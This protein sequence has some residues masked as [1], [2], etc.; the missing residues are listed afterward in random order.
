MFS[1]VTKSKTKLWSWWCVHSDLNYYA[2]LATQFEVFTDILAFYE[3]QSS[4]KLFWIQ[5]PCVTS[6]CE[7][8][9]WQTDQN[10]AEASILSNLASMSDQQSREIRPP[11]DKFFH[12][13]MLQYCNRIIKIKHVNFCR[14][15]D[16]FF[17]FTVCISA[18]YLWYTIIICY[19]VSCKNGWTVH[20][21]FLIRVY[22]SYV[23]GW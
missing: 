21:I 5:S 14:T 3:R 7:K 20:I 1:S 9:I 10:D 17:F 11:S 12:A 23:F 2:M 6:S 22:K 4:Q 15:K 16:D 13:W 19:F 18:Y 8:P